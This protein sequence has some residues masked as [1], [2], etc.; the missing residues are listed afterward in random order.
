MYATDLYR[1]GDDRASAYIADRIIASFDRRHKDA[2]EYNARLANGDVKP[3]WRVI[4]WAL[5]GS[6]AA[7][8]KRWREVDGQRRASLV[9]AMND[10]I[11]WWF[12]TGGALKVIGDTAQ[13]TRYL[14]ILVHIAFSIVWV[15]RL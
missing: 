11:K 12:W 6:R 7:R 5:R 15:V 10:S 8:E 1:L 2:T 13:I 14:I 3:R 9:W 4:W